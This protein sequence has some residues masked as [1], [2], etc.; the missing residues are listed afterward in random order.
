MSNYAALGYLPFLFYGCLGL[1]FAAVAA[2]AVVAA[3]RVAADI[4][5]FF[6]EH[7]GEVPADTPGQEMLE[8]YLEERRF[9]DNMTL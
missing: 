4:L 3:R 1:A 5:R 6:K 8:A 9:N 2:V 7:A